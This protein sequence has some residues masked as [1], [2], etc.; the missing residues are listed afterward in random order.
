M[1]RTKCFVS[2]MVCTGVLI[3]TIGGCSSL[4]SSIPTM[5]DISEARRGRSGEVARRFE[6]KREAA[7]LQAA[8]ARYSAGDAKG[9]MDTLQRLLARNPNHLQ[10]QLMMAEALLAE[11]RISE[12]ISHLQPV[13]QAH[14]DN[15][16]V[17][18][19]MGLLL[20]A[21]GRTAEA[22]CY[23]ELAVRLEP[24]SE[25][26]AVS[27]QAALSSGQQSGRYSENRL[28][29]LDAR[30]APVV[31]TSSPSPISENSGP[32]TARAAVRQ[33][34]RFD[35]HAGDFQNTAF[36]DSS[37]TCDNSGHVGRLAPPD[38][39][40]EGSEAMSVGSIELAVACF[41][42]AIANHP[43]NPLIPISAGVSSLRHNRPEVA[44][45]LLAPL[46]GVFPDS[47]A[48]HRILGTAY[49]RLGDYKSSQVALQQALSLD[50]S[51]ALA[52]FLLGCVSERLG[53]PV[54]A[55]TSFRQARMIDPRYSVRR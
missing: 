12:A 55:E 36:L 42:E 49:Y 31:A 21:G 33:P 53:Q 40:R 10:G 41:E 23:Y 51:S 16:L 44:V 26:Y 52:Y 22:L 1:T 8:H 3:G 11:N 24:K 46:V 19:T 7:E 43:E 20:D 47:A 9:C 4:R 5:D 29:P 39:V 45:T 35:N 48:I 6:E 14:A 17:Q 32:E 18:H 54:A 25:V 34:A 50:K 28:P 30:D 27:Y 15:S 38:L 13:A 37:Q 2:V